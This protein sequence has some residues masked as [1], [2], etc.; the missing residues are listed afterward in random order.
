MKNANLVLSF[1]IQYGTFPEKTLEVY[2]KKTVCL[3]ENSVHPICTAANKIMRRM[4]TKPKLIF[5]YVFAKIA[6]LPFKNAGTFPEA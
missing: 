1:E 4:R 3:K 6:I 5:M 2:I